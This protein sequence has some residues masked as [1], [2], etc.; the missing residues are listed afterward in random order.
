MAP[1]SLKESLTS[2]FVTRRLPPAAGRRVL[3]TFDDG[4]TPGVTEGVL[5]RLADHDA[6]AAFFVVGRRVAGRE[7]LLRDTAAR[8]HAVC[9]HSMTHCDARLPSPTVYHRDIRLAH[10]EITRATG[11]PPPLFRAPAGRLHPASLVSPLLLG[12]RHV[13]WSLDSLDWHCRD[14]EAG[15]ETARRVLDTVADG[16]IILLHDYHTYIHAL[17]DDLLPGLQER[18]FALDGGLSH[19]GVAEGPAS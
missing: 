9:N 3:L 19:L 14:D 17:L 2:P 6:C 5:S 16:D 13:L 15:R 1:A 7:D 11:T 10:A 4:P 12:M 8:G 18:G